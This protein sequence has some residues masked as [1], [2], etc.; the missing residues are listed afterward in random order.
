MGPCDI[1]GE[2]P[3][4]MQI[5]NMMD[6]SQQ[7]VCVPCFCRFG[8]DLAKQVL[9]PEEIAQVIGPMFV[10]PAREDLHQAHQTAR[11]ARKSKGKATPG[12]DPQESASAV[13]QAGES[14]GGREVAG[15]A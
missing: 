3:Q 14:G 9:P 8:L 7:F 13:E 15:D 4:V 1:C 10:D 2:Q 11:G 5:G 6:G 12:V